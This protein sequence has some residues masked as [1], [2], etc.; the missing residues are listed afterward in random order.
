MGLCASR[1][2][3]EEAD[4]TLLNYQEEL[5]YLYLITVVFN[6]ARSRSSLKHYANFKH[7][8][9]KLG[10]KLITVECCFE[11]S[12]FSITSPNYEP[13]NIQIRTNSLFFQKERL[14]NL[15][16]SKLPLDAKYILYV[17]YEV[18]FAN[19]N[20]V[21]DAIKAL[22]MFKGI[23]LFEEAL[24]LGPQKEELKKVKSF[25]FQNYKKEKPLEK[26]Q[27]EDSTLAAGFA[28]GFRADA[29]KELDGLIDYSPLGNNDKIM[30]YCLANRSEEYVSREKAGE[31]FR[32]SVKNWQKKAQLIFNEGIG[33]IPGTI[34]VNW[35]KVKRDKTHYENW[36]ILM[37][38]DF[39]PRNDLVLESNGIYGIEPT[40]GKLALELRKHFIDLDG[41]N[42]E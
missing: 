10:V 25:A 30:A 1:K 24:L 31:N 12:P 27:F 34:R 21:N 2:Q 9:E 15:A 13:Y 41:E 22:H 5:R 33:F 4:L 26:K 14:I 39:D 11:N 35:I 7:Q 28:W 37:A 42:I 18:E 17:D 16:I 20:W 23:Q 6:P 29:L 38:N 36:D 32:D 19:E 3:A 40:R 8:M